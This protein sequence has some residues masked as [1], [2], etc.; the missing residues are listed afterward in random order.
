M[1][2]RPSQWREDLEQLFAATVNQQT[3]E[4]A[5]DLMVSVSTS[6]E[7]YHAECLTAIDQG[8]N[9]AD[10]GDRSVIDAINKSG[11]QV[12]TTEAAADLLRD[13]RA[14]YRAAYDRA[15]A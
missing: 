13:L 3:L 14:I 6:D 1:N 10:G 7:S 8:I 12:T 2:A 15:R 5:A 11:Y 4:E 9:A